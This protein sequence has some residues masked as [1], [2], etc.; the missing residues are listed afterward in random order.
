MT[1][2]AT[3]NN[4]PPL[5]RRGR[6]PSLKLSEDNQ[7]LKQEQLKQEV[8]VTAVQTPSEEAIAAA[9]ARV[10]KAKAEKAAQAELAAK[11][12]AENPVKDFGL[13]LFNDNIGNLSEMPDGYTVV[14]DGF[15]EYRPHEPITDDNF[16]LHIEYAK[17]RINTKPID[18]EKNAK[19]IIAGVIKT[20]ILQTSIEQA[21]SQYSSLTLV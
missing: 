15:F 21:N 1:D 8:S 17:S 12:A 14:D 13:W 20:G 4:A 19:A 6:P 2:Q 10:E 18:G 16:D 11:Q 9:K 5:A 7:D 3:A